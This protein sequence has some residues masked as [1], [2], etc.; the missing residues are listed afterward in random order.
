MKHILL[1]H[2]AGGKEMTMLIEQVFLSRYGSQDFSK[3]DSA[4]VLLGSH[5]LAFTTDSFV[6]DPLFF[7]GGDIGR[8]AV[9]GTVND[10]LTAAARPLALSAS[11]IL[12]EGLEID[13]LKAIA[14]SMQQTAAECGVTIVTGDTK[15]VPKG[16]ADKIFITTAGLGLV[17]RDG[18]SGA[19]ALPGDKII[20]TGSVGDHGTA[21]MLA[22]EKLLEGGEAIAS[23]AAPL[24]DLVLSLIEAGCA[25]HTM[26]DPTRGGIA[27]SLNEIARQSQVSME[28]EEALIPVNPAVAAACEALGLDVFKVANEGKMLIIVA[29]EDAARALELIQGKR[30][31][32]QAAI[33]GAVGDKPAGRVKVRTTIGT[34]RILDPPSGDLLPRIC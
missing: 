8:L 13:T 18:V 15:V 11:F 32:T 21:V 20:L 29:P 4:T 24:T 12:E 25:V 3:D 22:R 23:D 5:R 16:S 31:G 34:S 17:L 7:P 14:A 19:A 30:Y 9:A 28:V 6:V 1:S 26:R 2:G 27:G 33:I 10:L